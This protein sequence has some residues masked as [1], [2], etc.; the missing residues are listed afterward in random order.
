M[1]FGGFGGGDEL[2]EFV[3]FKLVGVGA[4]GGVD[5]DGSCRSRPFPSWRRRSSA[6]VRTT[7]SGTPMM[8]A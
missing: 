1:D 8:L 4:A 5:E 2:R 6:G 7:L 3:E